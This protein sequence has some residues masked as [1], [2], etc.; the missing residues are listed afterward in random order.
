[1]RKTVLIA[2]LAA[3]TAAVFAPPGARAQGTVYVVGAAKRSINPDPDGTFAGKPVYLG[4]Y[5]F[6]NGPIWSGIDPELVRP[7]A[8][9]ILGNGIYARAFVV[10][11]DNDPAHALALAEIETQ[12]YFAAYQQG[13]Y[14]LEDIRRSISSYVGIPAGRIVIGGNHTHA[15]PDTLGVWGGVPTEYL[16]WIKHQTIGAV[17]DAWAGRTQAT[18]WFGTADA[19]DG[20]DDLISNQ[21]SYDPANQLVD[22]ELRVLQARDGTGQPFATLLNL[23]AHPTVM[24]GDNT[25]ISADW[26]GPVADGLP[27]EGIVVMG[28]LGRSQPNDGPSY[29]ACPDQYCALAHY[30][31]RVLA[32]ASVAMGAAQELTG[33]GVVDGHSYLVFEPGHNALLLAL[34]A[35]GRAAGVPINR[36]FLPPWLTANLVGTTTF[37]ARI[38]S[39]LF[40]GGPGELYPQVPGAVRDLVPADGHF[41]FGLAGDM[42]GYII[43]PFPDAYP[44]PVRRSLFKRNDP[45]DPT[46]W[47]FDPISNDNY[48]FNV[49]HTLGERVI[50]SMLRG[51][52]DVFGQGLAY[53]SAYPKCVALASDVATPADADTLAPTTPGL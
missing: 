30:A 31:N 20:V 29:D 21:F 8:S 13:P 2:C 44:E 27:G 45:G 49:G 26:P 19:N 32:R 28:A 40:S 15:G 43:A 34:S 36:S 25:K 52:G 46:T 16:A 50:C 1:M 12:G 48:F 47:Q 23:S 4:G 7:P 33:P 11:T 5:G 38:G 22:D 51:A 10:S 53:W 39:L 17:A 9:G 14:G 41:V 24:G 3:L 6:G 35:G 37:S 18:L 42:L